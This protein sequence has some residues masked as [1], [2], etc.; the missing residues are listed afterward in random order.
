MELASNVHTDARRERKDISP[1]K[2]TYDVKS[3]INSAIRPIR[4]RN[5]RTIQDFFLV[6]LH[7]S[8]DNKNDENCRGIITELQQVV[9]DVV[10]FTDV[11]ECIDFITDMENLK[12]FLILS[13]T[14]VQTIV[15]V[16]DKI[17]QVTF[18]YIFPKGKLQHEEWTKQWRK[19]KSV[20]TDI[21]SICEALKK[22]IPDFNHNSISIS[23]TKKIDENLNRNPDTLDSSFM[24]TQLLKEILLTIDFEQVHFDIFIRYCRE[25]FQGDPRELYNVDSIEK[26]YRHHQPIWWYT[27]QSFLYAMLNRAL[28][29][30]E[31]DV[32]IKI[33]FFLRDLHNNIV[34]V[35]TV[36]YDKESHSKPFI[37]YRGQGLSLADFNQVKS[38]QGGLLSFNNFLSASDKKDVSLR[39][40]KHATCNHDLVGILFQI[41]I[42]PSICTTPFASIKNL[43]YLK[44]ESEILFSMHSIFRIGHAMQIEE[45]DRLQQVDLTL[46]DD[47]DPELQA[48]TAYM[49]REY[50][51]HETPWCR[52]GKLLLKISRFD[53][54]EQVL[55][56]ILHQTSDENEKANI[57]DMLGTAKF[58]QGEY[59]E[60]ITFYEKSSEI[61]QKILP[62]THP[63]LASLYRDMSAVYDKIGEYSKALSYQEKVL[64]IYR[65]NT[66]SNHST[67]PAS[68]DNKDLTNETS[69]ASTTS[70]SSF[71]KA[72]EI[73]EANLSQND[74]SLATYYDLGGS[75]HEKMDNNVKAL[76]LYHRAF[77][78]KKQHLPSNHPSL[79]TSY[80]NFG[81]AYEKLENLPEIDA[82]DQWTFCTE[83]CQMCET[84][85]NSSR[86]DSFHKCPNFQKHRLVPNAQDLQKDTKGDKNEGQEPINNP[87]FANFHGNHDHVP[88]NVHT[89]STARSFHQ[90]AINIVRHI[91][92]IARGC[93]PINHQRRKKY[94]RKIEDK[95]QEPLK[96]P[97]IADFHENHDHV[98]ENVY[99]S[100]TA[101]S[102]Y[103]RA[104]DIAQQSLPT[105]H[106][107][108]EKYKR[109][110]E[111]EE[112]DS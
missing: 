50:L 107:D 39:F 7:S 19:K 73:L 47:N 63:K 61:M 1:S 34:A 9:N 59:T 64:E 65:I 4:Q 51:L 35:H 38:A 105:N 33:G 12:I 29:V 109:K 27:N 104:F 97:H 14:F 106:P 18:M 99:I 44:A 5:A 92:D 22:A 41:N 112:P 75:M 49:R 89:S 2:D 20:F 72:I 60:A 10:T 102:F 81:S 82:S 71:E 26:E 11:D 52:L 86:A 79:A 40:T 76:S 68:D 101:H 84:I 83:K 80:A 87:D 48:L 16:V 78:I 32:L 70:I 28:R 103:Q 69:D 93:L 21:S 25:M 96:D 88:E 54:A 110:I 62:T 13:E 6:W 74:L 91:I 42:D 67:F 43:S 57:Y 15:P 108:R 94:R 77:I 55:Q 90:R 98:P 100:S 111:N 95:E 37:V 66:T 31:V 23:F 17:P 8:I 3:K 56:D 30:M 58:N 46:T 85:A 36:Q 45:N 24:Y 53:T